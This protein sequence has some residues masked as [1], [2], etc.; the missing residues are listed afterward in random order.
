MVTVSKNIKGFLNQRVGIKSD[1]VE[2]VYNG[3]DVHSYR[4]NKGIRDRIRK[5]FGIG[6]TQPVIGAIG[7]L[8][9][10]KGH[11]YF[12]RAA[13]LI[14]KE[15]PGVKLLIAGRGSLLDDLKKESVAL[16][17][18]HNVIFLGY[19]GDIPAL[20]QA[21]DIFILSSISEGLPLS[22]LEAMACERPVVATNV[23][24]IP[25]VMNDGETGFLV[26][27]RDP[28]ALGDRVLNLLKNNALAGQF[29]EAGRARVK[30][31]FEI[32]GMIQ[33]YHELYEKVMNTRGR[34]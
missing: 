22:L 1:R 13:A 10:V 12:L 6:E 27:A 23:G 33:R 8:S 18:E 20:L 7:N 9:P 25:E 32:E 19:R 4:V 11:T 26:A 14:K 17:L 16:G 29:G 2:V 31:D 28:D 24:G 34:G 5:D 30:R 3:I 21:I 15:I